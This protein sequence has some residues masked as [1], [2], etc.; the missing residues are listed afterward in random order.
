MAM[1]NAP[2]AEELYLNILFLYS[3]TT[4]NVFFLY[5]LMKYLELSPF[6]VALRSTAFLIRFPW[7]S[8]PIWRGS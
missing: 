3:T 2:A 4:C 7:S 1:K 5:Q 6:C 8:L